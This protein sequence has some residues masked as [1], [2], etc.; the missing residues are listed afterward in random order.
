VKGKE[1][2]GKPAGE[3]DAGEDDDNAGEDD[4]GEDDDNALFSPQEKRAHRKIAPNSSINGPP[5][6]EVATQLTANKRAELYHY[7]N[8]RAALFSLVSLC[9]II[10]C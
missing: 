10:V 4:A 7:A 2:L 6:F 5:N 1:A 9:M 8:K 3:D